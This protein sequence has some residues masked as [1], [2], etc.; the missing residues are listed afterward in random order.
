MPLNGLS[1]LFTGS[2]FKLLFYLFTVI[3]C[4]LSLSVLP[5]MKNKL[6]AYLSLLII[7]GFYMVDLIYLR[8]NNWG[9]SFNELSIILSEYENN[10]TNVIRFYFPQIMIGLLAGIAILFTILVV[11]KQTES[12][13]STNFIIVPIISLLLVFAI[14]FK[15]AAS[16]SFR[17]PSFQTITSYLIYWKLYP[18]FYGDR[19]PLTIYPTYQKKYKNILWI[20]D[21]SVNGRYLGINSDQFNSTPFL[22]KNA[23]LYVN[24]GNVI[25]S[26]NCSATTNIFLMGMGNKDNLPD[27]DQRL[28]KSPN[29]FAFAQNAG[30]KTAYLSGQSHDNH[31]QNYMTKYDLED[32]E[33]FY[34]PQTN[35][36]KDIAL[37]DELLAEE[38]INYL[39]QNDGS[40]VYVVKSGSHFPWKNNYPIDEEIFKPSMG[41]NESIFSSDSL[42]RLNTY[43]NSIR[44]K[45]DHFFQSLLKDTSILENTIIMYTSDHGQALN[46][47]SNQTHCST[48]NPDSDE[49]IVPLIYFTDNIPKLNDLLSKSSRQYHE[50]I[51]SLT[52]LAMGYEKNNLKIENRVGFFYGHLFPKNKYQ[53]NGNKLILNQ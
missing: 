47:A 27:Y 19:E 48:Y 41:A 12:K 30:F 22:S 14:Q 5:M 50:E 34:Q 45:T 25:S 6:I 1:I 29:I 49:G 26:T 32:I 33:Y 39:H 31:L 40:F 52:L 2:F 8:I 11:R 23:H 9:L 21:C 38:I 42:L 10:F 17:L 36:E 28:L 44:W 20:L 43:L 16:F 51:V 35:D 4:I 18:S 7:I 13:F 46:G 37:A 15:T 53:Q 24:A 3:I